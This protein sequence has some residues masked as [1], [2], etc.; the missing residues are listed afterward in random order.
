MSIRNLEFALK[1]RSVALI[2]ASKRPGSVGAVLARN[3]FKGGFDGPIMPV[4]PKYQAIEG[5]LT[6]PSIEALP[7]VPDL[8]VISTPPETVPGIVEALGRKGTRAAV[9]ITAGFG[10]SKEAAGRERQQALLDAARPYLLRII[11]PNCLGILVPGIG[12]NA[13]FAHLTPAKGPIAF[14][15]QSGAIITSVMD[16]AE[17]RGIGFSHLVSSAGSSDSRRRRSPMTRASSGSRS[18]PEMRVC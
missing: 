15:A 3:L 12:L 4:N 2:G 5:V 11:G 14:V 10:E 8:A 16:W 17:R 1:P 18:S 6:Y 7:L 9:A 13:S